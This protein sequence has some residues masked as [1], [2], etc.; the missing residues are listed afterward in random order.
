MNINAIDSA[1]NLL[2]TK[3]LCI[4]PDEELWVITDFLGS[5]PGLD[6]IM[7][8][9]NRMNIDTKLLKIPRLKKNG[10]ELPKTIYSTRSPGSPLIAYTSLSLSSTH[11]RRQVCSDG[12][13]FYSIP[14][15]ES[16]LLI[17]NVDQNDFEI[18]TK[19]GKIL[20]KAVEAANCVELKFLNGNIKI[21]LINRLV[22][23]DLGICKTPGSF[24]SPSFEVNTVPK[25][26]A[27]H[28][29]ISAI[30]I[31]PELGLFESDLF[32]EVIGGVLTGEAHS[33][34]SKDLIKWKQFLSR[35]DSRMLRIAE[36][37][38]GLNHCIFFP[39]ESYI[40]NESVWGTIHIGIGRNITL[41]GYFN[42]QGHLD[43]IMKPTQTLIGD[44]NI[45]DI[46]E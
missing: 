41:G 6:A 21:P 42:A 28:G 40:A 12:G 38:F 7:R 11:F 26:Y 17:L 1:A 19:R 3:M 23:L 24:A 13:R 34:N 37:G 16:T 29:S 32:L 4:K 2:L 25:E 18:M 31:I 43:I 36:L 44:N 15:G 5:E 27:S 46:I 22:R 10:E 9:S 30:A 39:S 20:Q 33:E 45:V 35:V 8:T 14:G